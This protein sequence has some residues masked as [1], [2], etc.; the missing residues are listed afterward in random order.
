MNKRYLRIAI[1][2][3]AISGTAHANAENSASLQAIN[4]C[5]SIA[6]PSE[7]LL[8]YDKAADKLKLAEVAGDIVVID[9]EQIRKTRKGL[10]GFNI[11]RIPFLSSN[12]DDRAQQA[13]DAQLETIITARRS[14]GYNLW[15]LTL[16]EGGTW[17]TTD[18]NVHLDPTV[19][20][21]IVIKRGIL[22]N[23]VA[24]IDPV[25]LVRLRRVN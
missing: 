16:A 10:F 8:C 23:Y 5:R 22:G 3:L 12:G 6:N 17:E 13:Q 1:V 14:L 24:K 15:R 18:A 25:P 11:P 2:A 20:S 4:S 7:R 19:G 9:R 21:K